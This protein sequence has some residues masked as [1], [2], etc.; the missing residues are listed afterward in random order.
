MLAA[1]EALRLSKLRYENNLE[2]FTNLSQKETEFT[3]SRTNYIDSI[4]D[5]NISQSRIS[6]LMGEI[7]IKDILAGTMN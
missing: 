3:E 6:Y 5:Y 4:S 7:N 1:E 2:I